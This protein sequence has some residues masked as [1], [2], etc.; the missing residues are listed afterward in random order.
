MVERVTST[1]MTYGGS[2]RVTVE[3]ALRAYT[4][5]AAYAAGVEREVGTIS[6]RWLADLVVLDADPTDVETAAIENIGVVATLV[7]GEPV[8]DPGQLFG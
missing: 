8:H 3:E 2:E 5:H 1:G 6:A 4:S 7:G